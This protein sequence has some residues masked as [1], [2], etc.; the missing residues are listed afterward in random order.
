METIKVSTAKRYDV[1]TGKALLNDI[2][3][4][5]QKLLKGNKICVVTD[6]KVDLIYGDKV[7]SSLEESGFTTM[8]YVI[9]NG[10]K[11]KNP[12]SLI[13]ILEYMAENH[14]TRADTLLALGGGVV[15][16]IGGFASSVYLRGIH[17]VAVPTTLLAM[18]DSSIGGKT[19]I[20]LSCG[21]NLAGSFYQP[22]MVICDID[23][24]DTLP[25]ENFKSGMAEVVKYGV[26]CDEELFEA[27][28]D[29]NEN[30]LQIVEKCIKI[31]AKIVSDDEKDTGTRQI[32]NFGHT[33]G[34]SIEK[35]SGYT[36]SHG[37]AVSVGMSVIARGCAAKKLCSNLVYK[38]IEELLKRLSLPVMCEYDAES[39]F[40]A[41][42]S[43]KKI[44]G[45]K[46]NVIVPKKIGSCIAVSMKLSELKELIELGLD[47][48]EA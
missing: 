42:L 6:D 34:H 21:K 44:N 10:E 24:I 36:V 16:D 5:A 48:N 14:M 7:V 28:S 19:A 40:K 15:G 13:A 37:E 29:C 35:L 11:S 18:T 26:I 27:L 8:K 46:I 38:R 32:L 9:E 41:C 33:V 1:K 31:K 47:R 4:I 25:P 22:D 39:I 30:I 12:Q 2:G 3:N 43:D 45:D 20:N 23:T 17:Y